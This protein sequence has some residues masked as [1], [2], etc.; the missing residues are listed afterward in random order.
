MV[1]MPKSSMSSS[2][3]LENLDVSPYGKKTASSPES[4]GKLRFRC[5]GPNCGR[6]LY[7]IMTVWIW[8]VKMR[9]CRIAKNFGEVGVDGADLLGVDISAVSETAPIVF[10]VRGSVREVCY[11]N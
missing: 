6:S 4:V 7:R 9:L 2:P 1:E 5:A 10:D 11:L 8:G 3:S